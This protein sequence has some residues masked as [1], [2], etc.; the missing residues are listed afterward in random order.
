MLVEFITN[1]PGREGQIARGRIIDI[2][3]VAFPRNPTVLTQFGQISI[4]RSDIGRDV[5]IVE[6]SK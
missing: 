5:K 4:L 2:G 1:Y 6:E 3:S